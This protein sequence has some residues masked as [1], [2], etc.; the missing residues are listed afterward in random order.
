LT[1][2]GQRGRLT[3]KDAHGLSVM[4]RGGSA[5]WQW[6]TKDGYGW[7]TLSLGSAD[8][9]NRLDLADP[10]LA[11]FNRHRTV[12]EIH[13]KLV[14]AQKPRRD[15]PTPYEETSAD[16]VNPADRLAESAFE[17]LARLNAN[18]FRT[19]FFKRCGFCN[20]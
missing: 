8:G 16:L 15:K 10:L 4:L 11:R 19:P 18:D 13:L 5:V 3:P 14:R 2:E 9:P 1:R 17:C 12:S 6:K 20:P 7:T